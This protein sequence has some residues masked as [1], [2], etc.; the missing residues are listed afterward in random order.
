M[1]ATVTTEITSVE[2][3]KADTSDSIVSIDFSDEK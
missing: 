3:V 1:S 2:S